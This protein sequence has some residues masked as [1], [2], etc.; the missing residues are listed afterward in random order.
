MTFSRGRRLSTAVRAVHS[1]GDAAEGRRGDSFVIRR[2]CAAFLRDT[3]VV[4]T[5][6]AK[7]VIVE[8]KG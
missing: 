6:A 5:R 8:L 7:R 2:I 3:H 1:K 4:W